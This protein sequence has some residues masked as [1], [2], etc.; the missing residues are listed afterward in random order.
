MDITE[1]IVTQIPEV[2]EGIPFL[3]EVEESCKFI[4]LQDDIR[5]RG[6]TTFFPHDFPNIL[7]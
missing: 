1:I 4:Y 3:P 6:S 2:K 5:E 7:K